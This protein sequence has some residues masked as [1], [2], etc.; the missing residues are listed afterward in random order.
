MSMALTRTRGSSFFSGL[1]LI[2]VG[3]LLLLHNYHGYDLREALG[4]W[5]PL[6]FIVW[7]AIKLFERATAHRSGDPNPTTITAGE[8][9]LVLGL[10]A[11]V[12]V[13]V[14]IDYGKQH[15]PGDFDFG[16]SFEYDLDAPSKTITP[17]AHV[18]IR[19]GRGNVSVRSSDIAEIRI[20]GKKNVKA[21]SDGEAQRI[22]NPIS[23]EVVENGDGYEVHPTG[24]PSGDSRISV[25]LEVDVPLKST[26]TIRNEKGDISA[27]DLGAPLV[28]NSIS[29]DIDIRD[30]N[31]DVSI[32]SKKGDVKVSD[33]KGNVKISG[34]G[35][36]VEVIS[37]SGSFTLDG[38]FYGPIRAEKVA[39]GV[40]FVSQRTDL[41]LSQLTGH[42][43]ASPGSLEI[44]DVPG[45]LSVRAQDDITIENVTGKLK[46]DNRKGDVEVRFSSP[47]KEEVEIDNSSAGIN[48]T[49]PESSSFEITADCR[50]CDI[51]SEFSGDSLKTT[52]HGGDHH[53]EGK[54]GS[55]HG[56]KIAL[57]TSHGTISI[58]KTS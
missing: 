21:W 39:K 41:T 1:I 56:P 54:Y 26:V 27:S 13:V 11:L 31:G 42:M 24:L 8:V 34:H 14:A 28:V 33:T 47:P 38:E 30:T 48:I 6:I 12:A 50:N 57:T 44:A 2:F 36:Q 18:T 5:W 17:D 15:M 43:E 3:A 20:S 35:G 53:L 49:I 45:N 25:D 40:R 19:N 23:V 10:M 7:G 55:G 32:D 37:A 16:N 22:A 9:F 51:E 46:V 4:R 58:H 29:G 52:E